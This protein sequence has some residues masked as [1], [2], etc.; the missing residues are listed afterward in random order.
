MAEKLK[1]SLPGNMSLEFLIGATCKVYKKRNKQ[2]G[3][4]PDDTYRNVTQ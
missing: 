4:K 1:Q 2:G 3:R